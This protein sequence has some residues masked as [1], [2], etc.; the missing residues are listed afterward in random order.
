MYASTGVGFASLAVATVW[1]GW[2]AAV[3][4]SFVQHRRWMVRCYILLCSAVVLRLTARFF[5]VTNIAG[6]W[7]YPMTAWTS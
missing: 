4:R 1:L 2:R 6:D 3:R 7:I 5:I